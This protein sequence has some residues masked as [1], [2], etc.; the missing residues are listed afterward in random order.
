MEPG[1]PASGGGA[2]RDGD[3]IGAIMNTL[4]E[5]KKRHDQEMSQITLDE[6]IEKYFPHDEMQ[7]KTLAKFEDELRTTIDDFIGA[8]VADKLYREIESALGVDGDAWD[9]VDEYGEIYE[10]NELATGGVTVA[11]GFTPPA[12]LYC[13][14][15]GIEYDTDGLVDI[16]KYNIYA[17]Y[18]LIKHPPSYEFKGDF[19]DSIVTARM[20]DREYILFGR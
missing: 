18:I 15:Y 20:G 6:Y 12:K 19:Y 3:Q 11:I 9:W 14:K 4:D 8:C 2:R 5:I 10:R 13:S 1:P 16:K 7:G 17:E